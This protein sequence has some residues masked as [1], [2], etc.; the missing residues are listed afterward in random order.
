MQH[1]RI[2]L[3]LSALVGAQ[4]LNPEGEIG[5]VVIDWDGDQSRWLIQS[6]EIKV[7]GTFA[8]IPGLC[9]GQFQRVQRR[10]LRGVL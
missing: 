7:E 10:D 9:D 4:K 2:Y 3:R 8:S 5:V 6:H 1:I